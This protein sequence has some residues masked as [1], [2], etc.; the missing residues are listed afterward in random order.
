MYK[1]ILVIT[2]DDK[3]LKHET[4][5]FKEKIID[6]FLVPFLNMLPT[7]L[8]KFVKKSHRSADAVIRYKT[9][10]KA[11][12]VLYRFGEPDG[13]KK[14]FVEKIFHKIWFN[15]DNA[16]AVRNRL[17]ITK[18][19]VEKSIQ[20]KLQNEEN[21]NL[22]SIASGSA[23]GI[24]GAL[25]NINNL[26]KVKVNVTFLDKNEEAIFYSKDL[27][28]KSN[29]TEKIKFNWILD[30]ANNFPN[31]FTDDKPNIIEMVGLLDYFSD[32][33]VKKIFKTIKNNSEE[34]FT[35]I[36]A[37]IN[38]NKEKRFIT[39]LV[40]WKMVYRSAEELAKLASDSFLPTEDLVAYYEPLKVHSIL[41]VKNRTWNSR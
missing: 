39:N 3:E 25:N 2:D 1:N 6:F 16:K 10:H 12:E 15:T 30:T 27:V 36:T 21:I 26:E 20:E 4:N 18:R 14:T 29:L 31:Y 24:V 35:L 19:E 40:G 5:D 41:V 32:E 13:G 11:L 17:R 33:Q 34:S 28:G 38:N 7:F 9:T 22:L 37:N 8:R 23:R